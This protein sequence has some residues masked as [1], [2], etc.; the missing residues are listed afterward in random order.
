MKR[1][2]RTYLLL[3]ANKLIRKIPDPRDA[4]KHQSFLRKKNRKSGKQSEIITY[5]PKTLFV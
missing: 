1:M 3:L 4:N 5:Q 2:K